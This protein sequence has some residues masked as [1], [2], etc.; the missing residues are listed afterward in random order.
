MD[1][2][3]FD[4]RTVSPM[5]FYPTVVSVC[6]RDNN[7]QPITGTTQTGQSTVHAVL[8]PASPLILRFSP[9]A[10]RKQFLTSNTVF[11]SWDRPP[12][13]AFFSDTG[14]DFVL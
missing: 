5:A 12:A 8:P 10:T 2:R 11:P 14:G 3:G 6:N 9:A 1:V 7:G 13:M 4:I